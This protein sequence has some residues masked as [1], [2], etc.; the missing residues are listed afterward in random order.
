MRFFGS[1]LRE[2]HNRK[3]DG[4]QH[5]PLTDASSGEE[6][7]E[8]VVVRTDVTSPK[9]HGHQPVVKSK[10][11]SLPTARVA[12]ES[13]SAQANLLRQQQ[14]QQL[15]TSPRTKPPIPSATTAVSTSRDKREGRS[16]GGLSPRSLRVMMTNTNTNSSSNTTTQQGNNARPILTT[17]SASASASTTPATAQQLRLP[18]SPKQANGNTIIG[19]GAKAKAPTSILHRKKHISPTIQA[20]NAVVNTNNGKSLPLTPPKTTAGTATTAYDISPLPVSH[21][22]RVRFMSSGSVASTS[23]ASQVHLMAGAAGS[24]ASSSAMSSSENNRDN[25]FD[26]VLHMVMAEEN[27]RLNAM[28]MSRADPKSDVVR[29]VSSSAKKGPETKATVAAAAASVGGVGGGASRIIGPIDIDTGSTQII[30]DKKLELDTSLDAEYHDVNDDNVPEERWAKLNDAALA[31]G[32]QVLDFDSNS[33]SPQG[34]SDHSRLLQGGNTK[35]KK[36]G[37]NDPKRNGKSDTT[38]RVNDLASF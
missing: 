4:Q 30:V 32:M 36:P 5:R 18:T 10:D 29:L 33:S 35:A 20:N 38:R 14:Q 17:T 15:P 7:A 19:G 21:N 22:P 27:V 12:V 25:V 2:S 1:K 28:G 23:E 24:V 11:P 6:G 13:N 8:V 16:T 9:S 31:S 37:G 34:S 26:R 3:R